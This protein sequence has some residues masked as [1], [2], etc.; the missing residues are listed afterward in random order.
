MTK[1]ELVQLFV[2]NKI[3]PSVRDLTEYHHWLNY[4]PDEEA[5]KSELLKSYLS[6]G[7]VVS[8]AELKNIYEW[9]SEKNTD[10][11]ICIKTGDISIDTF[12]GYMRNDLWINDPSIFTR[13]KKWIERKRFENVQELIDL[14]PKQMSKEFNI[15][16]KAVGVVRDILEKYYGIEQWK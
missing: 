12:I 2:M 1:K 15:G 10:S 6:N 3:S 14:G 9:V 8:L 11:E 4:S 13:T 7:V 16:K 5:E